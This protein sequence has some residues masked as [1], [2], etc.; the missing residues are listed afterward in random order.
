MSAK[1]GMRVG[2]TSALRFRFKEL[3][4]LRMETKLLE[5][6]KAGI[7]VELQ[8]SDDATKKVLPSRLSS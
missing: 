7:K 2:E 1:S 4:P 3:D 5:L 6:S 8:V